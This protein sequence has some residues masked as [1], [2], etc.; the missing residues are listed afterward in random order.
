MLLGVVLF[1]VVLSTA[2]LCTGLLSSEDE[3]CSTLVDGF[4][5]SLEDGF[6]SSTLVDGFVSCVED[7]L[8]STLVDGFTSTLVDGFVSSTL[9]DGFVSSFE[10][11]SSSDDS[12]TL[13]EGFVSSFDGFVGVF[14]FGFEMKRI[15]YVLLP[16]CAVVCEI[17]V[18]IKETVVGV[19]TRNHGAHFA[20]HPFIVL[21]FEKELLNAVVF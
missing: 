12:G 1:E 14:V 19:C 20:K 5:S 21:A 13:V 11:S 9:V 6:V 16:E 17:C 7:E 8:S 10:G 4:T 3:L 2:L 18:K 15:L